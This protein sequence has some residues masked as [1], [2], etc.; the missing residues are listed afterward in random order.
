MRLLLIRH[1]ESQ[2]NREFRLQGR[3]DFPLTRRGEEQAT[4]LAERLASAGLAAVYSSPILRAVRTA[5]AVAASAGLEV[6]VE[7]GV[8]EYDFGETLSG[9]TWAEIQ[10]KR[11]ELVASLMSDETEFPHY[12]GEE[13]RAAFR[14]RVCAAIDAIA[15]R[16]QAAETVAIVTHAGPIVV[17]VMEAVGRSYSRPIPFSIDNASITTLELN[18]PPSLV[19]PPAV[20]TGLN[21]T[22]HLRRAGVPAAMPDHTEEKG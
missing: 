12:P 9:L 8:Q 18:R 3:T 15:D 1:A 5:E 20:L 2:G 13:G 7:P 14:Q 16:R 6:T 21:D 4:A 11:P 22:C 10:Q 19:M 17:Y